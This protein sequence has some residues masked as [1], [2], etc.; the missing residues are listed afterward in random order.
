MSDIK[1]LSAEQF[2]QC[3]RDGGHCIVDVRN[4]D[5]FNAGSEA[6]VCWPVSE[7]NG[8][9]VAR[10]VREQNLT[11][12]QTIILLCASGKRAQMAADKLSTLI[13]NPVAVVQ[14]GHGALRITGMKPVMSIERQVRIAAG[15]LVVL[16]SLAALLFN[17][18]AVLICLL[19]GAGLMVAG[20]TDWCGMGLLMMKMPWN[21]R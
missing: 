8:A 7:I 6:Q 3:Q 17:P 2:R 9:S 14:G 16:G 21:R 5:A 15:L 10:F 12:D 18:L 4:T 20:I 11:P 1:Q 19:V 13:P